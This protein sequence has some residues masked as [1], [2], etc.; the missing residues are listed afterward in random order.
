MSLA[1][2]GFLGELVPEIMEK[3]FTQGIHAIAPNGILGDARG[4]TAEMGKVLIDAL[5][6]DVIKSTNI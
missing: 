3:L 2:V 6:E 4:A 5:A 1:E